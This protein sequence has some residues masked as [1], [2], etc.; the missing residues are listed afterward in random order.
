[1]SD[2]PPADLCTD[3]AAYTA[4]LDR[5]EALMDAAPGSEQ[6][7]ELVA[8]A[9][10]IEEY[11]QPTVDDTGRG[12]RTRPLCPRLVTFVRAL[13]Q[14]LWALWQGLG[15]ARDFDELAQGTC[16][17]MMEEDDTWLT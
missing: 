2:T 8:L 11:E 9:E 3:D 7:Q 13:R 6:E 14:L 16:A 12:R 5:A 15:P 17:G 10:A 4:A 1:M